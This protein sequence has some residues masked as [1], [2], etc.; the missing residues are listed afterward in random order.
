MKKAAKRNAW[1]PFLSYFM[2]ASLMFVL[3]GKLMRY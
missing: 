2:D 3:Y 1:L